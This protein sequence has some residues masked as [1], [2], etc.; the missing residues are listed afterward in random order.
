MRAHAALR[1]LL[2]VEHHRLPG[3]VHTDRH[4]QAFGRAA[5]MPHAGGLQRIHVP[6]AQQH[7]EVRIATVPWRCR[8]IAAE[9]AVIGRKRAGVEEGRGNVDK[10][11]AAQLLLP[12]GGNH[13]QRAFRPQVNAFV[14]RTAAQQ[15]MRCDTHGDGGRRGVPRRSLFVQYTAMPVVL[16]HDA[17]TKLSALRIPRVR[18]P[19]QPL[20]A[21]PVVLNAHG[22]RAMQYRQVQQQRAGHTVRIRTGQPHDRE[23]LE[24]DD[25]R[26]IRQRSHRAHGLAQAHRTHWVEVFRGTRIWNID[27]RAQ[28]HR[29]GAHPH[30]QRIRGIRI[31]LPEA[32]RRNQRAELP[33]RR[34]A[35]FLMRALRRPALQRLLAQRLEVTQVRPASFVR[36]LPASLR[37]EHHRHAGQHHEREHEAHGAYP[38]RITRAENHERH[39]AHHG[40]D[41]DQRHKQANQRN[42]L[43]TGRLRHGLG[44][45]AALRQWWR[46]F[47]I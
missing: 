37:V 31:P 33:R 25:H 18:Q 43:G 22:F 28:C 32:R 8:S 36:I 35:V 11:A 9:G 47:P 17:D 41:H 34:I 42:G 19:L 16:L 30:L 5:A 23:G 45:N 1:R 4:A 40:R 39:H 26:H 6:V 44:I 12:R 38:A 20:P 13:G 15:R 29:P 2:Q 3:L 10:R 24:L 46:W 14:L 7:R 21:L 27:R